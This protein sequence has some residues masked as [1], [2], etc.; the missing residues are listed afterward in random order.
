[1]PEVININSTKG[2]VKFSQIDLAELDLL[3]WVRSNS[4][5]IHNKNILSDTPFEK[6][7]A[8]FY[9]KEY[10]SQQVK[11]AEKCTL[12]EDG[13]ID[14]VLRVAEDNAANMYNQHPTKSVIRKQEKSK[15]K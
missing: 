11:L 14:V 7:A 1:M 10:P 5:G 2:I 13:S 12:N 9:V 6:S 3:K 4:K 15:L 8:K